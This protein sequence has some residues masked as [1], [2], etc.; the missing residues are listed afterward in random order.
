MRPP[1]PLTSLLSLFIPLYCL[2]ATPSISRRH[3]P[4]LS[5]P[6]VQD[7]KRKRERQSEWVRERAR[8][9]RTATGA[10]VEVEPLDAICAMGYGR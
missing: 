5:S 9:G 10:F 1:I 4:P 6:F 8:Y 7:R 2:A 3:P